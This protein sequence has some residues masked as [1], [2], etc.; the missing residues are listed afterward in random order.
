VRRSGVLAKCFLGEAGYQ[1]R[2]ATHF[3][4]TSGFVALPPTAARPTNHSFPENECFFGPWY[5]RPPKNHLANEPLR[6]LFLSSGLVRIADFSF[7][8]G[9]E[10]VTTWH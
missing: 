6:D 4:E 8:G 10:N 7:D 3:Q 2:K 1:G 5:P 9:T